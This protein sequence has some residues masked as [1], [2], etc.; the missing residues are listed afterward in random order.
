MTP[1]GSDKIA[2]ISNNRPEC[3]LPTLQYSSWAPLLVPVYPTTN[4]IELNLFLN[5]MLR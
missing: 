4:P 1:E 5:V 2:I 3:C